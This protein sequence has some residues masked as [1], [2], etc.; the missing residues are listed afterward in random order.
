MRFVKP[1][2]EVLLHSIFQK[3]DKIITI[4]DGTII[5]GFGSAVLEFAQQY[6]YQNKTIKRLGIPDN[7]VE[8]GKTSELMS[9]IG[10]DVM[11]IKKILSSWA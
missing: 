7:F 5:G 10:L 3:Y 9:S 4:E 8:H 11:N 1:L 2:D 6:N